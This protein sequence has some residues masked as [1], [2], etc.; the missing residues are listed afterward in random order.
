MQDARVLRESDELAVCVI[1]RQP[2]V[3]HEV[4]RCL[5]L[6]IQPLK[7]RL[8][9]RTRIRAGH[10]RRRECRQPAG[11]LLDGQARLICH[12]ADLVQGHA[13]VLDGALRLTSASR[14]KVR[15]VRNL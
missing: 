6:R 3:L 4:R 2:Q 11:G 10:A 5:G 15:D 12:E 13:H 14:Q 8:E 9:G 1:G 7:H